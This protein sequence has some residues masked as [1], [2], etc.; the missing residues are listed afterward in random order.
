MKKLVLSDIVE[1][2]RRLPARKS[3]FQHIINAYEEALSMLVKALG[4]SASV[5]IV[6]GGT[7]VIDGAEHTVSNGTAIYNGELFEIPAHVVNI[8]DTAVWVIE[9][10]YTLDDPVQFTDLNSF[11]VHSIRKLKLQDGASGSG[12]ANFDAGTQ[13]FD[14]DLG[15]FL[16]LPLAQPL[17]EGSP[18]VVAP[19]QTPEKAVSSPSLLRITIVEIGDWNMDSAASKNVNITVP[20]A[21]IRGV[22]VLIRPDLI[23]APMRSLESEGHGY[24]IANQDADVIVLYRTT[25]GAFDNASFDSTSYNRGWITIHHV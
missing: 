8:A 19:G 2:V 9:T 10:T 25:S 17:A 23:T 15:Q 11:S 6:D 3:I 16:K 12:I 21:N 14:F 22:Q 4:A 5:R 18:F 20:A 24:F 7:V 1:N 13:Y